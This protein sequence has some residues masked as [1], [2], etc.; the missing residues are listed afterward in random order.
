MLERVRDNR[1][2]NAQAVAAVIAHEIRQPLATIVTN[3]DTALRWLGR[4][5]PNDDK[6]RANLAKIK[7]HS[8]RA[9]DV[10]W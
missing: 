8:H 4:V 3:A 7:S 5:P 6:A 9:S 1:L 10:L 2:L